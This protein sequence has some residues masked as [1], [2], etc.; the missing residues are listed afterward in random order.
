M[1][2]EE[3]QRGPGGTG[4]D[5]QGPW[6]ITHCKTNGISPGLRIK[7]QKGD[8]YL[9]KFDPPDFAELATGVD[10]IGAKFF[11]AAGYNVPENTVVSF[12]EKIL[13]ADDDLQCAGPSGETIAMTAGGIEHFLRSV[14]HTKDGKLRAIASKFIAG[15]PKGPFS[16]SG[17]RPDDPN[18]TIP[19]EHRRELRGLR[20]IAAFLNH[21]DVK[22]INTLDS[23]VEED[24]KKF[25][26]HY[27][28]DFG[29]TL[30]S[31]TT[32]PKVAR[33]GTEHVFDA[34][35]ILKAF[36]TLGIYRRTGDREVDPLHPSI[37]YIEGKEF[38]PAKWKPNY[39]I[40]AFSNMTDRDAYWGA[41]I[42]A[43]F[44]HEQIAAIVKTGRYTDPIAES[45]LVEILE[46]R[47]DRIADYYF[48]R[49]AP[50]DRWRLQGNS[51]VFDDLAVDAR[52]DDP[53]RVRYQVTTEAKN[54]KRGGGTFSHKTPIPVDVREEPTEVKIT[55]ISPGWPALSM[56]VWVQR[57]SGTPTIVGI[58]R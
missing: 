18:D 17:V 58:R 57:V 55:R 56:S 36:V 35:E 21:N 7:D 8:A 46:Q 29:S 33:E 47:R 37:G 40:V 27:L 28:I 15:K 53:V 10:A 25:L 4:P 45:V 1:S 12:D 50:M 14:G 16:Y 34:T 20:V 26:K 31:S 54:V 5:P 44:T 2:L 23:Y 51:L 42:V 11:Y 24:G 48:R 3:V 52:R 13:K 39:P 41:K 38:E 9:I 6:I 43:S 30:G 19:H 32:A 22:Q 49:I